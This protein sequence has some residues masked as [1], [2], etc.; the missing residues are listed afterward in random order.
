MRLI[1]VTVL[2]AATTALAQ[3][4][5]GGAGG[6]A[7]GVNP[8]GPYKDTAAYWTEPGLPKDTIFAPKDVPDVKLPV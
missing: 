3:K 1:L 2:S 7:K 6:R 8:T 4:E 5:G